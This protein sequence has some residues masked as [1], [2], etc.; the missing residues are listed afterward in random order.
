MLVGT[1]TPEK[2]FLARWLFVDVVTMTTE[3]IIWNMSRLFWVFSVFFAPY[4][5]VHF[6]YGVVSRLF[7][8]YS[9]ELTILIMFSGAQVNSAS[10][11]LWICVSTTKVS[12]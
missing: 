12:K 5:I 9:T 11:P 6:F 4:I 7:R 3:L 10:H 8:F 1:L 2:L